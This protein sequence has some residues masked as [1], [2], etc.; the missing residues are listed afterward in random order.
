MVIPQV[1][2][3]RVGVFLRIT[4]FRRCKP[5]SFKHGDESG[6][7]YCDFTHFV[8]IAAR[9]SFHFGLATIWFPVD[10]GE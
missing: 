8:A 1:K 6:V 5:R 7:P 9:L 2:D 4:N 10:F 3:I